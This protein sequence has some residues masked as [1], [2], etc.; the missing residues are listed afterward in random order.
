MD[1]DKDIAEERL[2]RVIEKSQAR[3]SSAATAQNR[4]GGNPIQSI[5]MWLARRY[6]QPVGRESDPVLRILRVLS[7]V[8]WSALIGFGVYFAY[9]YMESRKVSFQEKLMRPIQE[10]IVP[11]DENVAATLKEVKPDSYYVGALQN[12]NPFTGSGEEKVRVADEPAAPDPK[13][14]LAA[15]VKGLVVV[16]INRGSIPDAIVEDSEQKRTYFVKVDDS[17]NELTVVEIKHNS[18]VLGYEGVTMEI[19]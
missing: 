4:R 11:A 19:G 10:R 1:P 12:P 8:L 9:D 3:P 15:M 18:V 7:F 5:R 16:G 6:A 13:A 2:L 17:I 14:K